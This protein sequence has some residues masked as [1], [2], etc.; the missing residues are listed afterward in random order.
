[1]KKFVETKTVVRYKSSEVADALNQMFV[2]QSKYDAKVFQAH[3]IDG[4]NEVNQLI[5]YALLDELGEYHHERKAEWCWW[6]KSQE[7]MD[8]AKALEEFADI[9]HFV[10]MNVLAKEYVSY[11]DNSWKRNHFIKG[12]I[13]GLN[14]AEP[15]SCKREFIH[16]CAQLL[17]MADGNCSIFGN[18]FARLITHSGFDLNDIIQAYM[19]KNAVNVQR[20]QDG[21]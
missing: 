14:K 1:M 10:L 17:E 3:G 5:P 7:P 15:N 18:Y 8:K 21:Y 19:D 6:K 13:K 16:S 11:S 12:V 9:A 4:Y 20:V 2:M